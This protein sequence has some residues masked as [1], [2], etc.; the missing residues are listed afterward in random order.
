MWKKYL[1]VCIATFIAYSHIIT[2]PRKAA[3]SLHATFLVMGD[4]FILGACAAVLLIVFIIYDVI[5]F[6]FHS[7][8]NLVEENNAATEQHAATEGNIPKPKNPRNVN[9]YRDI[10]ELMESHA[11]EENP[12]LE[13]KDE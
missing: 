6:C 5:K 8:D 10:T 7:Q 1:Y 11:P 12:D 3:D 4:I 9:G 2:T 13:R